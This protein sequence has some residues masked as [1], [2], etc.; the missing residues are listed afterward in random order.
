[1]S[2]NRK[3]FRFNVVVIAIIAVATLAIAANWGGVFGLFAAREV[4]AQETPLTEQVLS[5]SAL[6]YTRST[7]TSAYTPISTGG[8][9]T[10][11]NGGPG[12]GDFS[13]SG[14][15]PDVNDGT[16]Y[17]PCRLTLPITERL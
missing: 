6:A 13:S 10:Q 7:F 2:N 9:A 14:G 12:P 1:M 11:L 15:T 16:A 3:S 5:P 17:I 4:A 8:G